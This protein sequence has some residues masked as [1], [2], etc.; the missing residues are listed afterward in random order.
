MVKFKLTKIL[1]RKRAPLEPASPQDITSASGTV[2]EPAEPA[3]PAPSGEQSA[4]GTAAKRKRSRFSLRWK[5]RVSADQAGDDPAKPAKHSKPPGK[6]KRALKRIPTLGEID[7]IGSDD[8]QKRINLYLTPKSKSVMTLGFKLGEV[9]VPVLGVPFSEVDVTYS[10]DPPFQYVN[11]RFDGEELVYHTVEPLLS[12]GELRYSKI[13][14]NAFEKMIQSEIVIIGAK[15]REEY[16]KDRFSMIISIYLMN[17]DYFQQGKMFYHLLKKY[18]GYGKIDVL[19]KDPY[20]EDITCNGPNSHIYVNHRIYGSV[21]TDVA[22]EEVELNNFVMKI[23]QTAGRHISVLQPIR[24]A[25]LVDGSRINITLGREVTR[26]GSTFTIRRFR[27]NPVSPV[28]LIKYGTFDSRQLAYLWIIL[29]Y[30]RSVLAAGGTASGKTTTLNA[31][32][33]FIRPE[34]KIVSIEDT[35][36]LNLL[37]PNWTQSITRSG[38]GG[39]AA[40]SK[41]SG[42]GSGK[43]GAAGD[44]ELYDLLTAALRQRPEYIVVGEVRGSEAF[45]LFQAISVGHPCLG[46][47]HAGSM[48]ELLSRVESNPMNVPRSLFSSVDNVI[49]NSMMKKGEHYIRRASGIVEIIE[50]DPDRGDLITNPIFKWDPVSDTFSYSG[51]CSLFVGIREEFGV[52]EGYLLNELDDRAEMLD[53]LANND[54]TDYERVVNAIRTYSRD[55]DAMM[56]KIA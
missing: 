28:D 2:T 3:E 17:L 15:N 14:E 36:E 24:D 31:L 1:R 43:G 37:H 7:R 50:I 34:H 54:I 38:F 23:A 45:T 56:E 20:I 33:A 42:N 6:F 13:I 39:E 19:M 35:A 11:V 32:C 5:K 26:K 52:K 27:T 51:S 55:K 8:I 25:T 53:H 41:A 22:F 9:S 4:L 49:F 44:I 30:K 40:L 29:E 18:I 48:K 12:E 16:L 46:T 10:V 47:I 21:R